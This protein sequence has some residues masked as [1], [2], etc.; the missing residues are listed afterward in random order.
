MYQF[1][2]CSPYALIHQSLMLHYTAAVLFI[3]HN[4]NY[5]NSLESAPI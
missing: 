3:F 2:R 4:Q 5:I 1:R